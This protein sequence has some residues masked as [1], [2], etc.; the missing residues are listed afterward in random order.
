MNRLKLLLPFLLFGCVYQT[1]ERPTI[2]KFS[3]T[4][5]NSELGEA[6]AQRAFQ[7]Y[8]LVEHDKEKLIFIVNGRWSDTL[9]IDGNKVNGRLHS[10]SV[11]SPNVYQFNGEITE[12]KYKDLK[13]EG[14]LNSIT[15]PTEPQLNIIIE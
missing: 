8:T 1:Y 6:S 4:Y 11:Y 5:W 3:I 14:V 7:V 15:V 12:P 2:R 9:F 10:L 13:I